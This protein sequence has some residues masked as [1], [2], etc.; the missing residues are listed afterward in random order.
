MITIFG[1]P[2]SK[3]NSRR[4]YGHISLPSKAYEAFHKDALWQLKKYKKQYKGMLY[5]WYTFYQKGKMT[6]DADNAIA[7]INDILQDAG[8]IEDDKM[9]LSGSFQVVRGWNEWETHIGIHEYEKE[10]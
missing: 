5:V 1:R 4:N 6:Q 7:S 3:K 8:I 9:I 10:M 2:C